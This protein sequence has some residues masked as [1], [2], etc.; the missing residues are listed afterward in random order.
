[1]VVCRLWGLISH[2]AESIYYEKRATFI[3]TVKNLVSN[4][5]YVKCVVI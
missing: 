2:L 3:L 1:M 5:L 4:I